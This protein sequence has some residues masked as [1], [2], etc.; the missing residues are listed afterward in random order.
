MTK[1][2]SV[3]TQR[4]LHVAKE[5]LKGKSTKEIAKTLFITEHTVKAHLKNIFTKTGTKRRT[6]LFAKLCHFLIDTNLSPEEL[7]NVIN[8][9]VIK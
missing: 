4:E 2:H 5:T 8:N 9:L 6:E 1:Q 7:D 3:L